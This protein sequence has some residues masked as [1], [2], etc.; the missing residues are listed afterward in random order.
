MENRMKIPNQFL[1]WAEKEFKDDI[2]K[3]DIEKEFDQTL[4]ISENQEEFKKKFN[5]KGNINYWKCQEEKLKFEQETKQPKIITEL[6]KEPKVIGLVGDTDSGKSNLTYFALEDLLK[7]YKATIYAYGLKLMPRGVQRINSVLEL[8]QIKDSIIIIDEMFSLFDFENKKIRREI[9]K[10]IRLIFHNNN[11]LLL[12]GLAENFKKFIS[13]KLHCIIYKKV[14]LDDLINGS[15]VKT[16]IMNYSGIERG[17]SVLDIMEDEAILFDGLH[18]HK[19]KIPYMKDY[20]TK[21]NNKPILIKKG[22]D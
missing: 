10:T 22:A 21:K 1:T 16:T 13:A 7:N 8:E 14:I 17:T 15:R 6:F 5:L 12:S 9:E 19:V 3:I 2:D 18:Y 11:V 4:T 20:D